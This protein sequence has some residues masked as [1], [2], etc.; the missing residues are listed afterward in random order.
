M[1]QRSKWQEIIK[2]KANIDWIK[3][4]KQ[5]K[6][7]NKTKS[8]LFEKISK[9]DKPLAKITKRQRESIQINKI[10]DEKGHITTD[11]EETQRIIRTVLMCPLLT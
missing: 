10:R 5:H 8:V 1:P 3:T 2:L 9:T 11:M 6:Q 7:T 4:N